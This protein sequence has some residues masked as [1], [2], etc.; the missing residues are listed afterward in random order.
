MLVN[1]LGFAFTRLRLT[2]AGMLSNPSLTLDG[3]SGDEVGLFVPGGLGSNTLGFI[4]DRLERMRIDASGNVGIGTTSPSEKL[5]VSGGSLVVDNGWNIAGRNAAGSSSLRI[6]AVD[7]SNHV[8]LGANGV[9]RLNTGSP[10]DAIVVAASGNVGIG[11]T[12]PSTALDVTGTVKA[13]SL[14]ADLLNTT[15]NSKTIIWN[16]GAAVRIYD[17]AGAQAILIDNAGYVGIGTTTPFSRLQV[18]NISGGT[19]E[20]LL[21]VTNENITS[22]ATSVKSLYFGV[23][24]GSAYATGYGIIGARMG[25]SSYHDLL[26]YDGYGLTVKKELTIPHNN[27]LY[28]LSSISATVPIMKMNTSNVVEIGPKYP[29]AYGVEFYTGDNTVDFKFIPYG[30]TTSLTIKG[31]GDVGVGIAPTTKFHVDGPIRAKSYTVANLPAAGTVGF[32]TAAYVS[33]ASTT[34]LLGL[35][36]TVAGSGSNKTPVWSDGTNWIIG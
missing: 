16:T 7:G 20:R 8:I 28:T 3:T 9:V 35:G 19:I 22:G 31:S 23:G 13:T 30:G 24:N 32:G 6:G 33:D 14:R 29:A 11:T 21:F 2:A 10:S 4:T 26:Q 12:S 25:D 1:S 15:D 34:F 27:N 18:C 36:T 17:G 5:H